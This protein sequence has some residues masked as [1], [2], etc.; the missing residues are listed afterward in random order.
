[1]QP[2]DQQTKPADEI[3]GDKPMQE[4]VPSNLPSWRRRDLVE[5]NKSPM[6]SHMRQWTIVLVILAALVAAG[7]Y[8]CRTVG[9]YFSR[10][11]LVPTMQETIGTVCRR[12]D[13]AE[14]GLRSWTSQRDDWAKRLSD[15]ESSIDGTLR[16][17]LVAR[18][19]RNMQTAAGAPQACRPEW[20][21]CS[22]LSNWRTAN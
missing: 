22:P 21:A 17:A 6:H 18:T 5:E 20:T 15:V 11:S 13:A 9:T 3:N 19:Q 10:L 16:T 12:I 8:S 1:M 2:L 14:D 4:T 7:T